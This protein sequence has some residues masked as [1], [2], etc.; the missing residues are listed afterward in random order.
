MGR[1]FYA[2]LHTTLS[3][4]ELTRDTYG[5]ALCEGEEGVVILSAVDLTADGAAAAS[6][7]ADCN[8]LA[9]SPLHFHDVVEDFLSR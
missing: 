5:I 3:S 7:V 9:L 4:G 2:L 1:L 6:L 8:R